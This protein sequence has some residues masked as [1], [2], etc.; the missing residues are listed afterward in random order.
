MNN[1]NNNQEDLSSFDY[2]KAVYKPQKIKDYMENPLIE[3]LPLI[4][5]TEEQ[6]V[7]V[8][9][10]LP[11]VRDEE[12]FLPPLLKTHIIKRVKRFIQPLPIHIKMESKISVLMRQSY[13]SRNPLKIEYKKRMKLLQQL[14]TENELTPEEI[15][16]QYKAFGPTAECVFINGVSGMGKTTIINKILERYPQI[17]RHSEYKGQAFTRTQIVWLKVD[18]PYDGSFATLCRNLFQE[19]DRLTGS[20]W[21]EKYGYLTRSTST[22][23]MY[24][25]TL[26]ANY[27]V[28]LLVIDEIQN[29]YNAKG[30]PSEMLDFFVTLTNMFSVPIVFIGTNWARKLF[31]K[32][33]RLAR[34]V[35][36]DGYFEIANLK[37]DSQEWELFQESL[38]DFHVLEDDSPLCKDIRDVFYDECQGVIAVAVMLFM[39]AQNL[40][41]SEGQTVL[42]PEIIKRTARED[43]KLIK[44][45]ITALRSGNPHELGKFDDITIDENVILQSYEKDIAM[46]ERIQEKIKQKKEAIES[47][48][49]NI[50]ENFFIEFSTSGLFTNLKPEIIRKVINTTISKS[51]I[52][53]DYDDLKDLI[54]E[55]LQDEKKKLKKPKTDNVI[56]MG[57]PS[58]LVLYDKAIKNKEHP[59]EEFKK[60][61]FIKNP[62]DKFL[63]A[64]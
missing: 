42:T 27:D 54:L 46:E 4:I 1:E 60:H 23:V 31:Q 34:R 10:S 21:N 16:N 22:M 24:L 51:D 62:F 29:L 49:S 44:P 48:R 37:K 12:R 19:I 30:D 56:P 17:I 11:K 20:R 35:Q 57:K 5:E 40:A 13:L 50:N 15:E 47:S 3:A 26:L 18:C 9:Y 7:D 14:K 41:I 61:G 43:L 63:K 25:T 39:F 53:T 55:L 33:F 59:Y 38:W 2:D 64:E 36:S 58:L 45:M 6:V 32:N 28:G 8:L 52:N